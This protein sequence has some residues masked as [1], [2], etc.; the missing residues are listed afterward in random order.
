MLNLWTAL[1]R[2][3][4][5]GENEPS[6]LA[7]V[8]NLVDLT[9]LGVGSTLGLGVY[10]LAGS[11]ARNE[12]G[13][14]ACLSFLVAAIASAVA[15]LCYAEFA[16]RVP[17][18]GSAYVYTYVSVGEFSAFI[19]GWN[20]IL[21][22]VI[23]T[24]SVARGLSNYI[25]ALVDNSMRKSMVAVMPINI[26]FL[27]DYPDFLSFGFVLLLTGLLSFGVK[28]S[29]I[30]N[31]LFTVINLVTVVI[32]LVA[33][34]IRA[35]PANW[36]IPF[37]SIPES[38]RSHA[39][40]G[41]FLP[42]GMAGVMAGAAKCFFAFVGFDTVATT[43]EEAKNPQ[44]NIPLAIIISLVIVFFAYFGISTVLTMMLPYYEQ[45]ADA[46]FPHVFEKAGWTGIKW[47]VTI[48]AIFALCTSM[49][50][51]MF[52][53]PRVIYAMASDGL[54]FKF[55]AKV[56]ARTKTPLTA[57]LFSGVLAAIMA[58]I[59]D[60]QQL[61]DMMSI[62]TLL[63]YTIVAI[64]VLILRYQATDVKTD[65]DYSAS[66]RNTPSDYFKSLFN[67]NFNKFPSHSTSLIT[68]AATALFCLFSIV[69][70]TFL[71]FFMETISP[72]E[73]VYFIIFI[74]ISAAALISM[75]IIYRQPVDDIKLSFK[76]PWV[77]FIPC[78]SILINVYLMMELDMHTWIRF[79]VWLALGFIIYFG[80]GIRQSE[81]GLQMNLASRNEKRLSLAAT[82]SVHSNLQSCYDNEAFTGDRTRERK[83][84]KDTRF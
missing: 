68:K 49:L 3:K 72:T 31:N 56:N 20:L 77:P 39:G 27:S 6:Q 44:K 65:M 9:A 26:D 21:E 40:V 12:A 37:D 22:Y 23:G 45:N 29:T 81:E 78:V 71:I 70:C 59:F 80:Y 61:V 11:V 28:E 13:P 32:V 51:C 7:R 35:D 47:I 64:C 34:S 16:S 14:A 19:I 10:V 79:V 62:G 50:G 73:L 30:L 60:L 66:H 54:L 42:F 43:G 4:T 83:S 24:A 69:L 8:L 38:E 48:G 53:L 41:G 5:T 75:L 25:D 46:P 17:R 18:A 58:T 36:N 84:P 63:A 2:R 55:L 57:T 76:V 52:P 74:V 67:L 33:G 1:N 15:G 82:A